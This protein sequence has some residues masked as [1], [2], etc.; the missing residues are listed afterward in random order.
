MRTRTYVI[1]AALFC[2]AGAPVLAA[3]RL[4]RMSPVSLT[5]QGFAIATDRAHG[6]GVEF[7]VERDLS[8]AKWQG[9]YATLEVRGEGGPVVRCRLEADRRK[10]TLTYRFTLGDA[11]LERAFLT[12]AEVQTD[13]DNPEGLELI[14]GGTIYEFNLAD[15]VKN[16]P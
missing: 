5:G 4:M 12:I 15:Y 8:Q 13:P 7:H 1:A 3:K 16:S 9:R 2:L 10:N 6:G 14:G 11:Q